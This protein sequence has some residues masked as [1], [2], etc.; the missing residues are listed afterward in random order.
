MVTPFFFK[1][2]VCLISLIEMFFGGRNMPVLKKVEC[3]VSV[4]CKFV[5]LSHVSC[6]QTLFTHTIER[7][8]LSTVTYIVF[9]DN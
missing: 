3:F 6:T 4:V 1:T 9:Q 5:H 8:L 2:P 7:S